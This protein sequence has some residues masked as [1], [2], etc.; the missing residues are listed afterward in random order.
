MAHAMF[1]L[2][3]AAPAKLPL[4]GVILPTPTPEAQTN[5]PAEMER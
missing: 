3:L 4:I 1:A 5:M 2:T